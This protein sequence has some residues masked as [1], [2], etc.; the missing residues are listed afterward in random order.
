M[1]DIYLYW[2]QC[3]GANVGEIPYM[4]YLGFLYMHAHVK[5]AYVENWWLAAC[6]H[7]HN[8]GGKSLG[9]MASH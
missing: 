9:S 6:E 3:T 7:N 1:Y 8:Y 4:E 5:Y 2:D